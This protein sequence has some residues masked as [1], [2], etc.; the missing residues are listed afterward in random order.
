MIRRIHV[1]ISRSNFGAT[2]TVILIF[3]RVGWDGDEGIDR[4]LI[5]IHIKTNKIKKHSRVILK[6]PGER[7]LWDLVGTPLVYIGITPTSTLLVSVSV[8]MK[9]FILSD[10]TMNGC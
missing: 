10:T 4:V 2:V 3:V 1:R 6:E 9:G 7:V 8:I 5:T